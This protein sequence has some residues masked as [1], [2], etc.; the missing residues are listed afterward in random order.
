MNG[1]GEIPLFNTAVLHCKVLMVGIVRAFF[2]IVS[3]RLSEG[4]RRSP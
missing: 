1:K 4:D 3:F 2:R